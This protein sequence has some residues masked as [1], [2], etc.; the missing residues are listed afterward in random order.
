[1]VLHNH[2]KP[3][4]SNCFTPVMFKTPIRPHNVA[5]VDAIGKLLC[6]NNKNVLLHRYLQFSPVFPVFTQPRSV[7]GVT[8]VT[9]DR[10]YSI[11][12]KWKQLTQLTHSKQR[13]ATTIKCRSEPKHPNSQTAKAAKVV[14][15]RSWSLAAKWISSNLYQVGSLTSWIC[16]RL[17]H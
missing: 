16:I 12:W 4:L 5:P 10:C 11:K 6:I 9:E 3:Y 2:W 15:L 1:M 7:H 14:G 8:T 17:Y 13:K